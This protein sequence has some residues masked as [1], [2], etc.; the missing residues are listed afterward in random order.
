MLF[1]HPLIPLVLDLGSP[2]P[3]VRLQAVQQ[4]AQQLAVPGF[5]ETLR[6]HRLTAFYY[7]TLTQFSREEVGKVPRLEELR[8][9]YLGRMRRYKNQ[10]IEMRSLLQVLQEAGVEP[11]VLKGGDIRYRLY[12]DPVTRPMGD[13][14]LLIPP[15]DLEKVRNILKEQGYT[16]VPRDI[17]RG[18]DFNARFLWEEAYA[19]PRRG[20][21]ALA[22]DLHWEIRKMGAYYRLP[23]APLRARATVRGV[24][25]V[26]ALVLCPEHLLMNLSLNALEEL[27][28]A[29]ILKLLDIHLTLSR[30]PITWDL[31]REDAAAFD[32][33]GPMF[34]MLRKMEKLAPGAVPAGVLETLAAYTP[35]RWE[36]LILRRGK[37]SLLAGF[38]AAVWRYLPVREWPAL[39][40]GKIWPSAEFIRANPHEFGSRSGYLQHLL[41]RTQDKT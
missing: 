33:Q 18:P 2:E 39:L 27:E 29:G 14:D 12:G 19:S 8:W 34:W 13:V 9:D 16:R 5:L 40:K 25:G 10:E 35:G 36:K 3:R 28:E 32:L 22:L 23:Y 24:G 20:E 1:A 6:E 4:I 41:R 30:A 15:A 7:S 38:L 11:L 31:F 26:R 17:D 37:G 21:L